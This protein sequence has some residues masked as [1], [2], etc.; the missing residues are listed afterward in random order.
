MKYK[1]L[2]LVT[3]FLLLLSSVCGAASKDLIKITDTSNGVVYVDS[4]SVVPLMR[5]NKLYLLVTM[6][7]H[8]ENPNYLAKLRNSDTKLKNATMRV[9]MYMFNNNGTQYCMPVRFIADA[10]GKVC[11]DMGADLV[12]KPVDNSVLLVKIYEAGYS[13]VERKQKLMN[14]MKKGA[15]K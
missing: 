7:E 2:I 14:S 15:Y 1:F 12:M 11:L 13:V 10:E 6:E 9:F 4:N 8:Y 5:D 3:L